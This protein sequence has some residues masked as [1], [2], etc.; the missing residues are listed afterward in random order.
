MNDFTI[1]TV[2]V[3]DAE[4]LLE[5][6]SHYVKNTAISFEYDPPT[7]EEFKSRISNTL[8]KYPYLCILQNGI[9]MGYAYA[10]AFHP[11]AAFQ[12]A[13]ETTV[14]LALDAR[15]CGLGRKLYEALE[16][17]LKE[18]GILNLYALVACPETEDEYLTKNSAEFHAH[19]GYVK[20]G[21][22]HNCGNKFGRWY[23]MTYMEKIIGEHKEIPGKN[24]C[25]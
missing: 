9:I 13:A 20:V 8:K 5:I 17:T 18:M 23:H 14:Y 7:L 21:E 6:Y 22:L 25:I 10:G 19:L 12:W 11:R 2:T 1:R 15:K 3:D 16:K 4:R 24:L